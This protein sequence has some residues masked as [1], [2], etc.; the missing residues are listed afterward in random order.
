VKIVLN[1]L[2][3][4]GSIT[5]DNP[6]GTKISIEVKEENLAQIRSIQQAASAAGQRF[7][8]VMEAEQTN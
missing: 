6:K 2:I 1:N 7:R 5:K 4:A 3:E 8:D